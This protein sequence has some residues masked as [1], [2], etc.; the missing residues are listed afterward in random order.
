VWG[1]DEVRVVWYGGCEIHI[2][3]IFGGI[4]LTIRPSADLK[5]RYN[6]VSG[7][8]HEYVNPKG[9]FIE[10]LCIPILNDEDEN[11]FVRDRPTGR[12]T[13]IELFD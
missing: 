7:L 10:T 11:L 9:S 2:L 8:Y 6:V 3:N 13:A 5:N 4:M 12:G 1:I